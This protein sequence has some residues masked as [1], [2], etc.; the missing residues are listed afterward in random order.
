MPLAH[1][2]TF[3]F[4]TTVGHENLLNNAQPLPQ[5][6]AVFG[7]FAVS[8]QFYNPYYFDWPVFGRATLR[9]NDIPA[10]SNFNISVYDS[11]KVLRGRGNTALYG[12]EKIVSLTL[13]PGRYYVIAERIFPKDLPNPS[14]Y[15]RLTLQTD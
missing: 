6:V 10:D 13:A 2:M 15:Y 4:I 12:G 5:N 11:Q 9:L 1:S 7:N 3:P 14:V 8:T